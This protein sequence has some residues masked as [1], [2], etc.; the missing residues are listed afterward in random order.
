M[1]TKIAM[2]VLLAVVV[3]GG[4]QASAQGRGSLFCVTPVGT[5][6]MVRYAR[7]GSSC[8]IVD[9]YT[10]YRIWGIVEVLFY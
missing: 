6:P 1:K 8:F 4:H 2:G 3:L 5:E 7:P 9:P 10:G